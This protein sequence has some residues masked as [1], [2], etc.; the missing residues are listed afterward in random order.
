MKMDMFGWLSWAM[1][2]RN[3]YG[4]SNFILFLCYIYIWC[5]HTNDMFNINIISLVCWHDLV[6]L[7]WYIYLTLPW[8]WIYFVYCHKWWYVEI[9]M[10]CRYLFILMLQLFIVIILI[11]WK[12]NVMNIYVIGIYYECKC[13]WYDG[14]VLL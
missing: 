5:Q 1:V 8:R 12:K 4:M 13:H 7:V 11:C 3:V 9:F 10:V 6:V 2:C 14:M